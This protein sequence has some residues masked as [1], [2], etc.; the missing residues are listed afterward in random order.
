MYWIGWMGLSFGLWGSSPAHAQAWAYGAAD[1]SGAC[2]TSSASTTNPTSLWGAV[3]RAGEGGTVYVFGDAEEVTE[4]FIDHS[5]TIVGTE[6]VTAA[7]DCDDDP[8]VAATITVDSQSKRVLRLENRS[9]FDMFVR[10]HEVSLSHV[11]DG[12]QV[13]GAGG[14]VHQTGSVVLFLL[15]GSGVGSGRASL[16]GGC[17]YSE[18]SAIVMDSLGGVSN[19]E[20][21]GKWGWRR[22][23]GTDDTSALCHTARSALGASRRHQ[24]FVECQREHRSRGW[25]WRLGQLR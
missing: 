13:S 11:Q 3:T 5:I 23:R 22:H 9:Q 19:C 6:T 20:A 7:Q 10:L 17:I 18:N 4:T 8:R 14:T 15:D 1:S 2:Q 12:G 21:G 25:W 24:Y 16:D